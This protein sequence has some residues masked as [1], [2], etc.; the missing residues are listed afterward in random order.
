MYH[1]TKVL[2]N[3]TLMCTGPYEIPNVSVDS[4]AV[5]TNNIPGGAFRRFGG[6][7]GAAGILAA[8][9]DSSRARAPVAAAILAWRFCTFYLRIVV[10]AVLGGSVL[11]RR[12]DA[13]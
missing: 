1:S 7:P 6:T 3:A 12:Q 11:R 9:D 13:D 4:Y 10:G 2:G 5:Y 8:T